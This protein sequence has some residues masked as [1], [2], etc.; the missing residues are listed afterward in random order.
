Q[1]Q[2]VNKAIARA[3]HAVEIDLIG[4]LRQKCK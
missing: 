1:V 3:K 4:S 2:Q